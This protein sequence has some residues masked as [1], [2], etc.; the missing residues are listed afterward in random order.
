VLRPARLSSGVVPGGVLTEAT[1]LARRGR[2]TPRL[3]LSGGAPGMLGGTGRGPRLSRPPTH[4]GKQPRF[5]YGKH[6]PLS[7][8]AGH[9]LGRRLGGSWLARRRV[10]SRSGVWLLGRRPGGSR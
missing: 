5:S 9:R 3:R 1:L 10:G 6:S 7:V 4:T 8:L 2:P